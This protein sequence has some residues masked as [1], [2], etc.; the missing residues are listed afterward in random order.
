ME[1]KIKYRWAVNEKGETVYID[2]LN[3]LNRNQSKYFCPNCGCPMIP[4]IG[5]K[6]Q[7]HFKH[8]RG[9]HCSY[10][11]YL[12]E[13]AKTRLKE[14]FDRRDIFC[15]E[16]DAINACDKFDVCLFRKREGD[17]SFGENR[18]TGYVDCKTHY[19]KMLNLKDLYDVCELEKGCD[20]FIP[21]VKFFNSTD[22]NVKP[23]FGEIFVSHGCEEKKIDSGYPIIEFKIDDED[24]LAMFNDSVI[25]EIKQVQVSPRKKVDKIV[26]YNL[27]GYRDEKPYENGLRKY[28]VKAR[29]YFLTEKNN[30]DRQDCDILCHDV[31]SGSNLEPNVLAVL[32]LTQTHFSNKFQADYIRRCWLTSCSI[33]KKCCE[34]CKHG[35]RRIFGQGFGMHESIHCKKG[36]H[37]SYQTKNYYGQRIEVSDPVGRYCQ[38]NYMKVYDIICDQFE[39]DEMRLR[40]AVKLGGC[41]GWTYKKLE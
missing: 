26:F 13:L 14:E 36:V 11:T 30:L 3:E 10:E 31:Y 17:N 39:L 15:I 27:N 4:A 35:D 19:K 29:K 28:A 41:V 1:T 37:V 21:D 33:L 9:S 20:N 12:H 5:E 23:L 7:A 34:H 6:R 8:N 22:S 32:S 40:E 38:N 16:V 24:D 18:N 2:T 25:K